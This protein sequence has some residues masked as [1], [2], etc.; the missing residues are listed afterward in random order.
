MQYKMLI[1]N[2]S[3]NDLW[4]LIDYVYDVEHSNMHFM[5]NPVFIYNWLVCTFMSLKAFD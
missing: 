2:E 5:P 4:I 1:F 3:S